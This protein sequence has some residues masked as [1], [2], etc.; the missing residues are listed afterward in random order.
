M[1]RILAAFVALASVAMPT[2]ARAAGGVDG[3]TLVRLLGSRAQQAFAPRGA[4]GVGALVRLPDGVRAGDVGL[5]SI[6]PG[7]ARLYGSPQQL[8]AFAQAHPALPFEVAP[9][10][11]A[12]LDT[13]GAY[14]QATTATARGMDGTGVLVGVADTGLDVTHADFLDAQGHS[15]VAWLL[16]LSAPPR[17]IYPDLE[18]AYGTTDA[19]GNI[20]F[21]AVWGAKDIDAAIAA[22]QKDLPKDE[23]GHGT[24]VTSCAAGNGEQGR[25]PYRGVAPGATII[26][27]RIAAADTEN[28]ANDD[29][30]RGVSFLFDRADVMKLPVVVNLSI[31]SDFGPHDGTTDWEQALASHVGPAFPG[32]ALVVAAGNSGS[33]VDTPVHQSVEVSATE[34][35][36]VT[37]PTPAVGSG[38]VQVWVSMHPGALIDVGLDGP[39]GTWIPP[40]QAG[41]SGGKVSGAVS[42]GVYNGSNVANS[43]VPA[44]SQ[45]AVVVWEGAFPAGTYAVTLRGSGAAELWLQG[46]GD[47]GVEGAVGFTYGVREGTINLPATHPSIIGVGCTINKKQWVSVQRIGLGLQVPD[48][49]AVGGLPSNGGTAHD[50]VTGEPCWFSSAGPTLTGLEKPEIMAPGAAVIGA[51]SAQAAPGGAASIFTNPSCPTK[52]GDKTDPYCQQIDATHAISFGTS[53]S[54]PIVSGAVAALFQS[55]PTLTQ[56]EVVAAL[57]GG[58]HMLRAR[59]AFEDQ[60]GVG[61]VDV[62]GAV[63]AAARQRKTSVSLPVK[64]KSWLTTGGDYYLADGSTPMQAIVELRSTPSGSAAPPVA[65]GFA[66][67]RLTAYAL[68]DGAPRSDAVR[69][70]VRRG[71]GVWVAT[72][73]LPGGLGGSSLTFGARFDGQDIVTPH[74]I[75]IAADAWTSLYEAKAKSA[76]GVSVPGGA[77]ESG[78]WGFAAVAWATATLVRRRRPADVVRSP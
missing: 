39:D 35:M 22:S 58:A 25:S 1:P 56:G 18:K 16:D 14:V 67:G 62:V 54:A 74:T 50:P 65:D 42:A 21:G 12:L 75:P 77:R 73:Q 46:T 63:E 44:G 11:H 59:S 76:C 5:A 49:D 43:P 6:A 2:V 61:E 26:A 17:G 41:T 15:R 36:R 51:M 37:I 3:A 45:G 64:A 23:A 72:V 47:L 20:V 31:G 10:L 7:L 29:M 48:L 69:S 68:V 13:A 55:D 70:L 4:P 40:I 66:E 30:L 38:G 57:Q 52:P 33:I 32:H 71:P 60:S 27:A 19:A 8:L 78:G 24:L 53:F 9:P 34:T 28:I